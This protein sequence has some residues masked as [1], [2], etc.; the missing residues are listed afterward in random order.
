MDR[1]VEAD[2]LNFHCSLNHYSD[3]PMLTPQHRTR[4]IVAPAPARQ[5]DAGA[6][7]QPIDRAS[8]LAAACANLPKPTYSENIPRRQLSLHC[9]PTSPP[10]CAHF[11]SPTIASTSPVS[12][13]C[14]YWASRSPFF[15]LSFSPWPGAP[16]LATLPS[17]RARQA[18]RRDRHSPRSPLYSIAIRFRS[19]RTRAETITAQHV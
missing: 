13:P 17:K 19:R 10:C 2:K 11:A 4:T 18:S 3:W 1:V 8:C 9:S 15:S 16:I 14:E 5:L 12:F 7:R 6:G